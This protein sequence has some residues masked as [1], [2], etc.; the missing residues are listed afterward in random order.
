MSRIPN[1]ACKQAGRTD[2]LGEL[3]QQAKEDSI[4]KFFKM[5]H[6]ASWIRIGFNA[7]PG[8]RQFR[9]MRIRIQILMT[10]NYKKFTIVK[11]NFFFLKNCNLFSFI[12]EV[13]ALGETF[14]PQKDLLSL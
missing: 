9:S 14:S 12:K 11:L 1:T 6:S 4:F 10:K 13:Q 7:D 5:F 2:L 3:G 8:T